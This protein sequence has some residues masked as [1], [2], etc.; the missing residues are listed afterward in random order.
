[1]KTKTIPSSWI[2]RWGTRLD[3]GP[4][5]SG[6]LDA[7]MKMESLRLPTQP[8]STVTRDIFHAGRESRKWVESSEYGIP[9][10]GSTDILRADISD[11][12]LMSRKQVARN[13]QFLI[14]YGWTLITR[15]G[16]IGRM[17]FVRRDMDGMAC[18]EHAMRVVPN[19]EAVAPGYLFAFLSSRYGVPMI[20][21][22]TYGSII[23]SIEPEHIVD[24]PV[25]RL[26]DSVETKAHSLV[27][28][29][30]ENRSLAAEL[31]DESSAILHSE[32]AIPDLSKTGTPQTYDAFQTNSRFLNRLDAAFHC[33]ACA[34]AARALAKTPVT[35]K[36]GDIAHV[37]QT[38]IFKRPYVDD[39][40]FGYPYYSGSELFTYGPAP[41]GHLNRRA[42]GIGDYVVH[43][44]WLLMQDAGQLGGL[45]GRVMRVSKDLDK[46]VVS[47]HL[48]RI[49]ASSR[50][51]AA[52]LFSVLRSP[53]GYR[54]IVR[55]AF[56]SSIPQLES[57][58]LAEIS[59]PWPDEPL[60]KKIAAPVLKAWD[61]ED[62][63]I[64]CGSQAIS[65]IEH[66]IEEAA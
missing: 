6:A 3:S 25:P 14:R 19:E 58:E 17:A 8:L 13:Q 61:L 26:G 18:S 39:P 36:F 23:Q 11:L 41:R 20:I 37:F 32:L 56:G 48:I 52:F 2:S 53:C 7:R 38:N 27:S 54:A 50:V 34:K 16:T 40:Q 63:A 4:Y 10:L 45:I 49:A 42:P 43:A 66:E 1:M 30:A 44:D 65:L 24:L 21:G 28:K 31:C 29:A 47:N 22:G 55:H 64:A 62:E 35:K 46:S 5:V 33:P 12:P 59:L 60:R 15:S 9:F 57:R 51:D